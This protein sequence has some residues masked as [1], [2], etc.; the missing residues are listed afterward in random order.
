MNRYKHIVFY[1]DG[2]LLDT[3]YSIIRSLQRLVFHE[4]GREIS[5]ADLQFTLGITGAD[6]LEQLGIPATQDK[7]DIWNEFAHEEDA[8]IRVFQGVENT[9]N[10]TI[11]GESK[12]ERTGKDL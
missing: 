1:V 9:L 3:E 2:T 8:T 11:E 5:E 12:H 4:Q 10:K 6:A 7:F